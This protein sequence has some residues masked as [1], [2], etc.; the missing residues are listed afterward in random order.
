MKCKEYW[1]SNYIYDDRETYLGH[2]KAY[3]MHEHACTVF[4]TSREKAPN[5][6]IHKKSAVRL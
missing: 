6:I 5:N 2:A 4:H 1:L 3:K